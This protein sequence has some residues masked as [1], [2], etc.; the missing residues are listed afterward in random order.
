MK[1]ELGQTN[2]VIKKLTKWNIFKLPKIKL[3]WT[4]N[5]QTSTLYPNGK[6]PK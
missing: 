3:E 5:K 4:L 2:T 6:I 1:S